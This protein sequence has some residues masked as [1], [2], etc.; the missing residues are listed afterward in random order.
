MNKER[1]AMALEA[2]II[3]RL[4]ALKSNRQ[5]MVHAHVAIAF[6]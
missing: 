1:V 5:C 4:V 3:I 6:P 2:V